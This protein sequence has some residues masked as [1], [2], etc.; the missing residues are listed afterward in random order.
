VSKASDIREA[1]KILILSLV[2]ILESSKTAGEKKIR[3][4]EMSLPKLFKELQPG[5]WIEKLFKN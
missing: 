2:D 5:G 1:D 3:E 4:F